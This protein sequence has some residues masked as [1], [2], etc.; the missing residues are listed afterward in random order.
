[1]IIIRKNFKGVKVRDY[2]FEDNPHPQSLAAL[3]LMKLDYFNSDESVCN[4]PWHIQLTHNIKFLEEAL[5]ERGELVCEYC[6]KQG[7]IIGS[8]DKTKLATV[9]HI[10]PKALGGDAFNYLNLA[11][12]CNTCNSKKGT[13]IG[14]R[15]SKTKCIF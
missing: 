1:M 11:V 14:T 2:I 5:E 8:S 10:M 12:A 9:D 15:I 13:L 7:L 6:G 3:L 4:Q